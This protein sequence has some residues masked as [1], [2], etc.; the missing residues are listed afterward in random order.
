VLERLEAPFDPSILVLVR[1]SV[2]RVEAGDYAYMI[3]NG[4]S[5]EPEA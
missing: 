1:D 4:A 5:V 3:A 2:T